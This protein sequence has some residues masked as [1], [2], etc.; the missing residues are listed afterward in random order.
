M[1]QH[2]ADLHRAG[3]GAQQHVVSHLASLVEQIERVVHRTRRMILGR[4]ERGEVVPVG[5]DLGAVGHFEADRAEELFDAI[6][7]AH[8]RVQ[9]AARLAATGQGHIQ[10]L[11]SQL[12][13]QLGQAQRLAPCRQRR[14]YLGLGD[15]DRRAR[16]FALFGR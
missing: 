13:L 1:R 16:C 10:R 3:V 5:F 11:G 7:R 6:E 15:V 12:G 9:A 14:L 8:H 4:V 2:G